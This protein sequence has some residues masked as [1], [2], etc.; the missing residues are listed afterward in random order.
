MITFKCS[1]CGMEISVPDDRAGKR[2]KCAKCGTIL[3]APSPDFKLA[4]PAQVSEPE[5]PTEPVKTAEP[6]RGGSSAPEVTTCP[7]CGARISPD[8]SSCKNCKC[9]F[10]DEGPPPMIKCPGCGMR[11]LAAAVRCRFCGRTLKAGLT[12]DGQA[13]PE[14]L[15]RDGF[16][17]K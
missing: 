8:G 17:P 9:W 15:E 13:A 4:D 3:L 10:G 6:K 11:I 1:G 12:P 14:F 2:G 7:Q 5:A 16:Y